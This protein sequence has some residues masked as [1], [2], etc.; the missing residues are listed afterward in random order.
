MN[1]QLEP[2]MMSQVYG[3]M[4]QCVLHS[5]EER[6]NHRPQEGWRPGTPHSSMLVYTQ[7]SIA[8]EEPV[9]T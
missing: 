8:D 1:P 7:E 3:G 2:G 4:S 6:R 5:P 9:R